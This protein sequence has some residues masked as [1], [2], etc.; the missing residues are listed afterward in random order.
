[1]NGTIAMVTALMG[2]IGIVLL[3]MVLM[4]DGLKA[5]AGNSFSNI[6]SRF[7]GSGIRSVLSG[8]AITALVQASSATILATIGFVSAGILTFPRA[9]GVIFGANLGSTTTG[10]IV[11]LVGFKFSFSS[12][13]LPMICIGALMKL[14]CKG[15]KAN[16]GLAIAGFGILFVGIDILQDGMRDFSQVIDLTGFV[17][18]SFGDRLLL[19]FVGVIMT[20][21]LQ[22]S[23]VALV[24]TLAAISA[25]SI[26]LEQAAILVIGQNVGK[27]FYGFIGFIGATVSAKRTAVVHI[28]F[29]VFTGIIVFVFLEFFIEAVSGICSLCGS[30]EPSILLCAFHTSFNLLGIILLLP[31]QSKISGLMSMLVKE[32]ESLLS[33]RLDFSVVNVPSIAIETAHLTVTEI[34]LLTMRVVRDLI[35]AEIPYANLSRKLDAASTG[36][37]ETKRF[38]SVVTSDPASSALHS[39]HLD[40]IHCIDHLERLNEACR[41]VENIRTAGHTEFL[42]NLTVNQLQQFDG[43]ITW[44]QGDMDEAPVKSVEDISSLFAETRKE[45]RTEIIDDIAQ[46]NMDP[47]SAF[48]FL[49]AMRWV[50]RIAYHIW[51]AVIHASRG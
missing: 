3:G 33:R 6:L 11:A 25:G 15:K 38:M 7:T 9:I 10:W 45:K 30:C 22:S 19:L 2:G 48:R 37:N 20:I 39:E 12:I 13:T 5:L 36:L 51:R 31:F 41:E 49:E 42:R 46:G 17:V 35:V 14:L 23:S 27:T 29:N 40:I 44:L 28:F 34:F 43:V 1:M 26:N 8:T 47:D 32:E 4:T 24:T 16:A 21:L 18:D 50:D